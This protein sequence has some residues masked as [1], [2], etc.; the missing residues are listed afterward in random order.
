MDRLVA[1]SVSKRAKS[2]IKGKCHDGSVHG[3]CVKMLQLVVML[4]GIIYLI[5]MQGLSLCL[6][7]LKACH[8]ALS[9]VVSQTQIRARLRNQLQLASSKFRI[10]TSYLAQTR[11]PRINPLRNFSFGTPEA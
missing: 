3:A 7:R 1:G 2:L 6:S 10:R 5:S 11:V 9:I 8:P 4:C